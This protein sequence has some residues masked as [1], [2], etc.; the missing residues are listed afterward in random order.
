MTGNSLGNSIN[1]N[2]LIKIIKM[3]D[4]NVNKNQLQQTLNK[5]KQKSPI[6]YSDS[7]PKIENIK[8]T[9]FVGFH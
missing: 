2:R 4:S 9:G 8:C 1:F 3:I 5:I 6:K 7:A